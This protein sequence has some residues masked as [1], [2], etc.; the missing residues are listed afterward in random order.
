MPK[1]LVIV[2]SP[3]KAKTIANF[4]GRDYI[5]ESS[6][7]H[8]RDLPKKEMGIDIEN[9]TFLPHYT[10][11]KER[12][13]QVAKLQALAKKSNEIIFATD[14]DREGEA[15]SWH[16]SFL[17][18]IDPKKA[19]RIVFHE[20]T[21]EAIK[22]A[23]ENPHGIDLKMVNAQ[24]ARRVVDRLVGYE[25]S[26]FLWKKVARGLSAGRVQSVAVRLVV[27]REREIQNFK[28][29]EYWTVS[30]SFQKEKAVFNAQLVSVKGKNLGK[31]DLSDEKT[32]KEA[33]S[34][35]TLE[36]FQV[37]EADSKSARRSPPPPFTTSI[38]QQQVNNKLG[39]SS[40]QTMRLAQQLYEGINLGSEGHVG[41]ITYMRTDS[42]NLSQ[43]FIKDAQEVIQKK[44]GEKYSIPS[45]RTFKTR[46]K[47]AQEAHEA[48]RPTD[49]RRSPEQIKDFLT[50]T[51]YKLYDL[52]WRRAIATQMSEAE[53]EKTSVDLSKD[54]FVFCG[55]GQTIVF[56][57]WLKL[58]P[59]AL[60]EEFLPILKKGEKVKCLSVTPE[61]HFTEPPA[62]YSDASLVKILEQH[63]IGRPS[64]YAPTIATIE[65][66]QYVERDDKKRLK[67]TEIA[68]LVNDLLVEH[69]SHI[70]DFQFTA[71]MENDLDAIA[72][73]E[74][75]WRPVV[76]EFYKPF[77]EN[78]VKKQKE[79]SKKELT[80]T[81]TEEV[82]DKCGKPMVIKTGRYGRFMACSGY[83]ECK[84]SKPLPGEEKEA[85]QLLTDEKCDLCGRP[86]VRKRGRFGFFLGCSGYPECKNIKKTPPKRTGV[87]CN[88]CEKGEFVEKRSRGN[89][90]FYSCDQYPE[91]KNA[92]SK[93]PTGEFCSECKHPLVYG[94][95]EQILCSNKECSNSK[96]K[97]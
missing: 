89:R 73:G 38:L 67:P 40:K 16:L 59:N 8:V 25:L 34:S 21:P 23:L 80:E 1:K 94:K 35:L 20:I 43:K 32:T 84:N 6:L 17:L 47:N 87:K 24:Q 52:I 26:P 79:L 60:G 41:L 51:Q 18:G 72:R 3:T 4:L 30:G 22:E 88:L 57:G 37:T 50:P 82:C 63:G 54:E 5:L 97:K 90:I 75:E 28:T 33:I 9:G 70:V 14:Q 39:F 27:E 44:F 49:P 86:M 92:L 46:S 2:E 93:K 53:L 81:A 68:F 65:D 29:K 12:E 42:V 76:A 77:H 62:R 83:P 66:R 91:C 19:K 7:G 15:I 48:I 96:V 13:E 74:K 95:D 61:Q 45:V 71:S 58:Y 85:E 31:F 36:N 55:Q 11:P 69:F 10:V 56:D 78:L 64:T